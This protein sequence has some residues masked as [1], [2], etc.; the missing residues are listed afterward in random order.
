MNQTTIYIIAFTALALI[1]VAVLY[2]GIKQI[3][4]QINKI[5]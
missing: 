5:K 1:L 4:Y 2:V 3:K